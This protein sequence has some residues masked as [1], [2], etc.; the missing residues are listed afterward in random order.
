[1]GAAFAGA[2]GVDDIP[3]A[4]PLDAVAKGAEDVD[5][6][7][8]NE[9]PAG[10]AG[11]ED[12]EEAPK[13]NPVEA[14]DAPKENPVNGDGAGAEDVDDDPKENPV[15]DDDAGAED[16]DDTPNENPA[17]D[18]GEEKVEP[19][20]EDFGLCQLGPKSPGASPELAWLTAEEFEELPPKLNA[21]EVQ[22]LK[23]PT[24]FVAEAETELPPKLNFG[25]VV[26]L[27]PT[28]LAEDEPTLKPNTPEVG[29]LLELTPAP[30]VTGLSPN[31]RAL[32]L[33]MVPGITVVVSDEEA[34]ELKP[35]VLP[36]CDI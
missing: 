8:P 34:E 22:L 11:T 5:E 15:C 2:E 1:M 27:S 6:E 25:R 13:E 7:A 21:T 19:K 4:N 23:G 16:A 26:P 3:K 36:G 28:A 10:G 32:D 20:I 30:S 33:I 18:D 31:L 29:P 12:V 9:N 17:G 35:K 24:V 14:D